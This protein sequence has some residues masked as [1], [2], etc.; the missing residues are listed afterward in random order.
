M[1]NLDPPKLKFKLCLELRHPHCVCN[2]KVQCK[3]VKNTTSL[4]SVNV[5]VNRM[6]CFGLLRSHHQV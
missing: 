6:T 5:V 1:L 2:T 4:L 3:E